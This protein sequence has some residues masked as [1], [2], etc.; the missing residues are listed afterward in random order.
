MI[1]N[2]LALQ[3]KCIEVAFEPFLNNF[4]SC[5]LG[6]V[7]KNKIKKI[8]GGDKCSE[9]MGCKLVYGVNMIARPVVYTYKK[10][11]EVEKRFGMCKTVFYK[12]LSSA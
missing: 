7:K 10:I 6:K 4:W 11:G 1:G 12:V 2:R 5:Q 3:N 9:N 8:F